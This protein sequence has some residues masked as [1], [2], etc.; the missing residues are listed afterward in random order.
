MRTLSG[1]RTDAGVPLSLLLFVI[2]AGL[3]A[4]A[5]C[6]PG[7]V[8]SAPEAPPEPVPALAPGEVRVEATGVA[9]GTDTAAVD[10]ATRQALRRAVEQ[11]LGTM[12]EAELAVKHR[13]VVRERILSRTEGFVK[14]YKVLSQEFTEDGAAIVKIEA[15]VRKGAIRDEIAAIRRILEEKRMPRVMVAIGPRGKDAAREATAA[16]EGALVSRGFR[17][18]ELAAGPAA[19]AVFAAISGDEMDRLAEAARTQGAELAVIGSASRTFERKVE[20]YGTKAKFHRSRVSLRAV[21]TGSGQVLFSGSEEGIPTARTG[22]MK[23]VARRAAEECI[24][25]V[26]KKW[27]ADVRGPET[28]VVR[29]KGISFEEF[30]RLRRAL[31]G[32]RKAQLVRARPFSGETG[33]LEVEFFGDSHELAEAIAAIPTFG[34]K[35]VSV[36][37]QK[38]ELSS[39]GAPGGGK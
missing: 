25:N 21:E 14:G 28:I 12:I 4:A 37:A 7:P 8:A 22:A 19:E 34:L 30:A 35:V 5:G 32:V 39:A 15:V 38:V 10:Q 13:R 31:E 23:E 33:E 6:G 18:I 3:L 24:E 29:V 2:A 26:L 17:L 16:V 9:S 20:V 27:S 1:K 11:A 36:G